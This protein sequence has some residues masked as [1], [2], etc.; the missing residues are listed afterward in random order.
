VTGEHTLA[1]DADL[2]AAIAAGDRLALDELYGRHAPWLQLRLTRRCSDDGLVQEAIQDTF[3]TVWR[4]PQGY[5]A[6]GEVGAWM[7]GIAIRQLL[8][9]MRRRRSPLR[10]LSTPDRVVS[11]EDTVLLAVEH[12]DVGAA[13]D[14]L[15]PELRTVVQAVVLDGLTTREA[16]RLLGIP[17]GTVKTR[18]MRA[19]GQL[20][21]ALT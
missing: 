16:A 3:L 21:E 17:A 10:Y 8:N 19:R 15:S 2:L 14:G 4:R 13:I 11:A 12:G 5:A 18:M 1:T 20:R 7:W 6:R 9:R